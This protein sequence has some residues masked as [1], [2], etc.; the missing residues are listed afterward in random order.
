MTNTTGTILEQRVGLDW[1][2]FKQQRGNRG[3]AYARASDAS[4][5]SGC[6]Y[7]FFAF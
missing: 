2:P 3:A 7:F 1:P 4:Y 5:K 6:S